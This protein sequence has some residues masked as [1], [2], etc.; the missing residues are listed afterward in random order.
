MASTRRWS[1]IAAP[2]HDPETRRI[3][4]VIDVTGGVE[5]VTPQAQL[6]VDATARAIE[7]ELLVA[8]LRERAAPARRPR[9]PTARTV[10]PTR[11]TLTV[12]GRDRAVLD[13]VPAR[14]QVMEHVGVGR[15]DTLD[16]GG[17]GDQ[18]YRQPGEPRGPG[19]GQ[20]GRNHGGIMAAPT[21][22]PPRFPPIR[23][24]LDRSILGARWPDPAEGAD[25]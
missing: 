13:H 8:R 14:G 11:A 23:R 6:L 1:C 9:R 2:V 17:K 7:G 21:L 5:A 18:A 3:L 10:E 4:G 15:V 19:P 16:G 24:R 12:L 20:P 25:G 22:A